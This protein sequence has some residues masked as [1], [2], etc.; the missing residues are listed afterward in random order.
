MYDS[1]ALLHYTDQGCHLEDQQGWL[2]TPW[3]LWLGSKKGQWGQK[4]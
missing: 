2:R 3:V 4:P 1:L